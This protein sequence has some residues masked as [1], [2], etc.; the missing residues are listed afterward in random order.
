MSDY[1]QVMTTTEKPEDAEA[2]ARLLIDRRLAACVQ[3]VGPITSV[4]RWQGEVETAQEWRVE[5]KSRGEFF[6]A[7]EHAITAA[8]PYD[9]PEIIAVPIVAG[10]ESYLKWVDDEVQQPSDS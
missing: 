9:E 5:A 10:S 3:I 8:H 1:L 6:S 4:Y 7:I 2:M